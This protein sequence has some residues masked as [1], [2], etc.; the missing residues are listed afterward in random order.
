LRVDGRAIALLPVAFGGY[1][2]YCRK[3]EMGAD[4][5][6]K[7]L[8]RVGALVVPSRAMDNSGQF[9][10]V[11]MDVLAI[12]PNVG[13]KCEKAHANEYDR[14]R[15]LAESPKVGDM[16]LLPF[17]DPARGKSSP[18]SDQEYFIEESAPLAVFE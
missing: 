15:W 16:I 11:V 14:P 6:E 9:K 8:R 18:Y 17:Y 10:Y 4:D 1:G 7:H 12:G 5:I 2:L 13:K 3:R